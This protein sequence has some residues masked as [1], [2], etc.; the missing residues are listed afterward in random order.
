MKFFLTLFKGPNGPNLT[1]DICR[2][3]NCNISTGLNL[4]RFNLKICLSKFHYIWY[5]LSSNPIST[6][7]GKSHITNLAINNNK[8]G[9]DPV[10]NLDPHVSVVEVV[11]VAVVVSG[12]RYR[13]PRLYGSAF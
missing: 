8:L 3:I 7:C 5:S 1:L 13:Q 9:F 12:F 11:Q 2:L 10:S 4:C 6:L